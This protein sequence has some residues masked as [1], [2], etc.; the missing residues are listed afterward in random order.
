MKNELY[1]YYRKYPKSE[2]TDYYKLLFQKHFGPGHFINENNSLAYLQNEC[3]KLK[4]TKYQ[5]LYEYL[6]NEY[7]RINLVPYLNNNLN[8]K[9]LNKF[10]INSSSFINN[11]DSFINNLNVL[12]AFLIEIG[13]K[14]DIVLNT[15]IN[16]ETLGYP[17]V[18]HSQNYKNNYNPAY[19]VIKSGFINDD[20][21]FIQMIQYLSQ[22]SSSNPTFISIY[23]NYKHLN[24]MLE[25]T[26]ELYPITIIPADTII[27]P[28]Q[29]NNNLFEKTRDL[30][31]NIQDT[32]QYRVYNNHKYDLVTINKNKAFVIFTGLERISKKIN[33]FIHKS[34]F[35][36]LE[37]NKDDK[38]LNNI[39]YNSDLII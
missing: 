2:I 37:A 23:N 34:I 8:L 32:S 28:N 15:F 35:I 30:I 33:P 7:V 18:H 3:S 5:D 10:F 27:D 22:L 21:R 14:K 12:S 4:K 31:L 26:K 39:K 20:L 9:N 11:K 29:P 38:V 17:P 36:N 16:Y 13:F 1:F 6:G 25:R 24:N 19:R